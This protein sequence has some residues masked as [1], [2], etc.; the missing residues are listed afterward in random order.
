MRGGG[1]GSEIDN[2]DCV[3]RTNEAAFMSESMYVDYGSRSDVLYIN[4]AFLKRKIGVGNK[5]KEGKIRSLISLLIQFK[6][7]G[8]NNIVVKG[9]KTTHLLESA[10]KAFNKI[11]KKNIEINITSSSRNFMKGNSKSLWYKTEGNMYEPTLAVYMISDIIYM[12]PKLLY[13]TGM[14]FY[15]KSEHW[16][17]VYNAEL[18]QKREEIIRR[19]T[20]H[21]LA[22]IEYIKSIADRCK[23]IQFDPL[24]QSFLS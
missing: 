3:I 4:N 8:V 11:K 5:D 7:S 18:D 17:G 14:D 2:F 22:D 24:L 6:N 21:I 1:A 16:A 10:I 20:H 23:F 9:K 13:V 15:T 19:K 12:R